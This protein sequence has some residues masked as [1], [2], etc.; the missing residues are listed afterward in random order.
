MKSFFTIVLILVAVCVEAQPFS[1]FR[2][3][4]LAQPTSAGT[5]YTGQVFFSFDT[6]SNT[7]LTVTAITNVAEP[8]ATLRPLNVA[9]SA[10]FTN[11]QSNF[12]VGSS[13]PAF[14]S[15]FIIGGQSWTGTEANI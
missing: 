2:P 10:N 9:W 4:M 3:G 11:Q 1:F 12:S 5:T 7:A 13:A 6:T 8:A 14:Y 15:Q